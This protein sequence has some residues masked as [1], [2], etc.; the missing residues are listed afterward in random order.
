MALQLLMANDMQKP[1]KHHTNSSCVRGEYCNKINLFHA[2]RNDK[3]LGQS[4]INRLKKALYI[5]YAEPF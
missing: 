4:G 1:S 2:Q 5:T 3:T